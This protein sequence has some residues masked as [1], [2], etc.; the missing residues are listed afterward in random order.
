[1]TIATKTR[2]AAGLVTATV[3]IVLLPTT[4]MA[5][6]PPAPNASITASVA[7]GTGTFPGEATQYC[8]W[9]VTIAVDKGG[10]PVVAS[11]QPS[12]GG[13]GWEP[14]GIPVP[15]KPGSYRSVTGAMK[16]PF[17][18]SGTT[19]TVTLYRDSAGRKTVVWGPSDPVA[20]TSPSTQCG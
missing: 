20:P 12:A 3:A 15:G 7:T 14:A 13:Q 6:P 19:F 11:V 16:G 17:V 5:A 8:T 9:D 2:T 4:A 1:M 10:G 18:S